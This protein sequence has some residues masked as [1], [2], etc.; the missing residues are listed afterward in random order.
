MQN[1][2]YKFFKYKPF[3]P[4]SPVITQVSRG[5]QFVDLSWTVPFNADM[6]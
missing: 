2:I 6:Q 3:V 1:N 4:H 5:N